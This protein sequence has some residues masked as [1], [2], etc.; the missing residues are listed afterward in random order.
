[1]NISDI[2]KDYTL[3]SLDTSDVTAQPFDQFNIWLNAA[4]K[5]QL[6]EPTAMTL[7]TV[8]PEGKPSARIVLLKDLN[9]TSFT[10]FTNYQSHKGIDLI[11]NPFAAL[12]FFWAELERQVRIEGKIEK[13]SREV[14]ENYF[15]SRPRGSQIGAWVSPQ[16]KVIESRAFLEEETERLTKLYENQEIPLPE[17]W[18]GYVLKPELV[19]F[20]QGRPSRL[21]DRIQYTKLESGWKIERLAP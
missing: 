11:Q 21:H 20:W 2:R 13:V 12:T 6:P 9:E 16:S 14:S 3:Q 7:A 4:I 15:H 17:H 18:G 1:M 5:A 8:S 19:E 10:F